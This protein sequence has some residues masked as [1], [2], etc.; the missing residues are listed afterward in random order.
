MR[1]SLKIANFFK[2]EPESL[3]TLRLSAIGAG[4]LKSRNLEAIE[5]FQK[6]D[7]VSGKDLLFAARNYPTPVLQLAIIGKKQSGKSTAAAMIGRSFIPTVPIV[8]TS[9][10]MYKILAEQ[11]GITESQLRQLPKEEIRPRLIEI[12]DQL[13]RDNPLAIVE[14]SI[15]DGEFAIAGIRTSDQLEA[16]KKRCPMTT[17]LWVDRE[18]HNPGGADNLALTPGDA[19]VV[20]VNNGATFEPFATELIK[21]LFGVIPPKFAPLAE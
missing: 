9:N 10:V 15:L 8:D 1:V 2:A 12:G 21:T 18:N 19:D 3:L 20:V 14:D 16:L 7:S 17:V 13:T 4:M 11:L 6:K 5:H